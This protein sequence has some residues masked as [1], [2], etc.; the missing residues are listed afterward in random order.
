M[1]L[2]RFVPQENTHRLTQSAFRFDFLILKWRPWRHF[3]QKSGDT[4]WV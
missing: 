4:S 1:K 3:T 2:G